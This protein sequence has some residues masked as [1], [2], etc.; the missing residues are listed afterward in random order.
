MDHHHQKEAQARRLAQIIV[1]SQD[2]IACVAC[3]DQLEAYVNAQLAGDNYLALFPAVVQHLDSCVDCAESY[4]LLYEVRLAENTAPLPAV[5][6]EPEY[7]LSA[8]TR[9]REALRQAVEHTGMRI[10]LTLTQTLLDALPTIQTPAPTLRAGTSSNAPSIDLDLD[11]RASPVS[12]LRLTM[13]PVTGATES[14]SVR[15]QVAL[16][17][18]AWPDLADIAVTLQYGGTQ[19]HALTDPWGEAVFDD[20]P[21]TALVGLQLEVDAGTAPPIST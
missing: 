14:Y 13:H 3:L 21:A 6:A 19:R 5:A 7:M 1:A 17:D 12:R 8:A 10:R 4:A 2:D 20:V 16:Y 9:L 15:V 11:D 18:R